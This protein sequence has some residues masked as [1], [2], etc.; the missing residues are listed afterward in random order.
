[1]CLPKMP[2]ADLLVMLTAFWE[3]PTL[4]CTCGLCLLRLISG[5]LMNHIINLLVG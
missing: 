3:H 4:L 2:L 5:G 1:M